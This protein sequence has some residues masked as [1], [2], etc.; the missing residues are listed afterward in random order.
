GAIVR[1]DGTGGVWVATGS[2]S[3]GQGHET[4]LAQIAADVLG[5]S[6]DAVTLVEG[7]TG[8]IPFGGGAFSSRT[9]VLGGSAIAARGERVRDQV[10]TAAA[11]LLEA[12]VEDLE[13]ADGHVMVRGVPRT[14]VPL[15]RVVQSG[16]PSFAVPRGD[17]RGF[18]ATVYQA[19][20]TV[21]YANGVHAVVV[22]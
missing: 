2:S 1:L 16:L 12:K 13:L 15:G 19:V 22:E 5:V 18:E 7:D 6:A 4:T 21:T 17:A 8:A 11:V 10:L 9:A 20:P 3:Q 14:A